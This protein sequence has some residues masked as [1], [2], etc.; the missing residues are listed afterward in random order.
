MTFGSG[1]TLDKKLGAAGEEETVPIGGGGGG[2]IRV[3][4]RPVLA[5]G[6]TLLAERIGGCTMPPS[7]VVGVIIGKPPPT[8]A[9][10][11]RGLPDEVD[12]EACA[13]PC[14]VTSGAACACISQPACAC[15]LPGARCVWWVVCGAPVHSV[16]K[17]YVLG[18]LRRYAML[19]TTGSSFGQ[20]SENAYFRAVLQHVSNFKR[21]F[22]RV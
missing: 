3:R 22:F 17:Q 13:A 15:R 19:H 21:V 5:L 1:A 10:V 9:G 12:A 16:V 14:M 18:A 8:I 4:D 2:G 11:E 20:R 7:D 6:K